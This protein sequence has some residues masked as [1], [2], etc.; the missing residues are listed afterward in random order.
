MMWAG[1]KPPRGIGGV[2]GDQTGLM[3][4]FM[5]SCHFGT[6]SS[7]RCF[8]PSGPLAPSQVEHGNGSDRRG[9]AVSHLQWQADERGPLQACCVNASRR[10]TR[11][12]VPLINSGLKIRRIMIV[13][14]SADL[15]LLG[16]KVSVK[17][18]KS[19]RKP[20]HLKERLAVYGPCGFSTVK[21]DMGQDAT[22]LRLS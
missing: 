3:A 10:V 1:S 18:R 15:S 19:G 16:V 21:S 12:S 20:R 7:I 5:T 14:R 8:M 11:T 22:T 6:S 9:R 2:Q 4:A 17:L 13:S